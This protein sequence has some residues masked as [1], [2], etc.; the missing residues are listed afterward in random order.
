MAKKKEG[1]VN[2]SIYYYDVCVENIEENMMVEVG[3]TPQILCNAFKRIKDINE[4]YRILSTPSTKRKYDRVW[5]AHHVSKT[6][7]PI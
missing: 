3:D 2:R 5:N 1:S 6:K 7:S 4:A